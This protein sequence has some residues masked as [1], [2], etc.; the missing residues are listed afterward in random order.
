MVRKPVENRMSEYLHRKAAKMHIPLS[1]TFELTPVC[2][3]N[4]K[5]CYVRMSKEQQEAVRPLHT[6]KEWIELGKTAKEHGL[7]YLLLTGGEPFLRADFRE[8]LEGLHKLGLV[9]SINT[10]GTMINEETISWLKESPPVRL[11]ITLYGASDET[12]ARLCQNP[13]GFTQAT[14]AIELLQEAGLAVKINCSI[15]PYNAPDLAAIID[16]AKAHNLHIQPTSYMFPPLR[17]DPT[18]IGINDRFSSKEAAYYAVKVD[19]LID[20]DD[21]FLKKY[22]MG[23]FEGLQ[24]DSEEDC[25]EVVEESMG[26][27]DNEE[28]TKLL[29]RAGSCSYWV[30]WDGRFLPCGMFPG[31]HACN[32]FE[33]DFE[34]AWNQAVMEASAIRMPAKCKNCSISKACKVCAAMAYTE[35]GAFDKVPVYRCQMA[36]EYANAC[37]MIKDEILDKR[38]EMR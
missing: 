2:N 1:G 12:Y 38:S 8:I 14:H 9:I 4:C 16:W 26:Q 35:T 33:T 30:T 21:A 10:N 15:T 31:E 18:K 24:V 13:K 32:V 5:M 19:Q 36:H 22:E 25:M 20:G 17:K 23:A 34:T 27:C 29:C 28:G 11:N 6:A 7:V 3:M 37:T